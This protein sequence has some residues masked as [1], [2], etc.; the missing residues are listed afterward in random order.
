VSVAGNATDEEQD[1]LAA[2]WTQDSPKRPPAITID[3]YTDV[4]GTS[5]NRYPA[6]GT[7]HG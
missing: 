7:L 6:M 2:R 1:E 3:S 5:V 4:F